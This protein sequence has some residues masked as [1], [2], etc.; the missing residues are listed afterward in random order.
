MME[1]TLTAIP[2]IA[3]WIAQRVLAIVPHRSGSREIGF[4][5]YFIPVQ[6]RKSVKEMSFGAP[7]RT[8]TSDPQLRKLMLYPLSYGRVPHKIIPEP[9][10]SRSRL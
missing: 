8:R 1:R 3:Q 2:V 4:T 7:E 6:G 5:I 10:G 9:A